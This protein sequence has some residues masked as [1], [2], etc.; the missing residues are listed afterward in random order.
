VGRLLDDVSATLRDQP[1][2][3]PAVE[4]SV[5]AAIGN[6]YRHLGA[7]EK[8]QPHLDAAL[9]LRRGVFGDHHEKVAQSLLD[10]AWT[11]HDRKDDHAAES[12]SRQALHIFQQLNLTP[13]A[14]QAS[15]C[16]QTCLKCL[17]RFE[18]A[19]QV[20][21]EALGLAE[22]AGGP[23]TVVT[24]NW[25]EATSPT[26]TGWLELARLCFDLE[27]QTLLKGDIDKV[28][29]IFI[30]AAKRGGVDDLAALQ[31]R[32]WARRG[33]AHIAARQWNT[34]IRAFSKGIEFGPHEWPLYLHRGKC[35]FQLEQFQDAVGDFTRA[36]Q[37]RP[38]DSSLWVLRGFAYV[39]LMAGGSWGF[40]YPNATFEGSL[41]FLGNSPTHPDAWS[42]Y[43]LG[44]VEPIKVEPGAT[45]AVVLPPVESEP[46]IYR[47]DVPNSGGKEYFLL[48]NRQHI[49]FDQ[50]L[51]TI[52]VPTRPGEVFS[53]G[54]GLAIWHVDD[55][56]LS[57]WCYARPNEAENWKEFRS[58]GWRKAWTG[59]SHYAISLIQADDRWDLEHFPF[60]AGDTGD[61]YPGSLGVTRFGSDTLP[62]SSSYYFWG[63]S[64]P[65]FGFSGVTVYNIAETEG[66][67]ITADL[68]YDR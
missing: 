24:A 1:N 40:W 21:R 57:T 23:N 54:H 7:P 41:M 62:N 36:V 38:Q 43:R 12:L 6:A 63:G 3:D 11:Y 25:P 50:A 20:A 32:E 18:E 22:T 29:K 39:R 58:E 4:A 28:R 16:L 37:I 9:A 5:R 47:M 60:A 53:A 56:I 45:V 66:G 46:V 31:I 35:F 15:A 68:S 42:K 27:E 34:A 49:G 67:I 51:A 14:V 44:F 17:G 33:Q 65:K 61:L 64:E 59:Q 30:E 19:E 10:L 26:S 8:A 55:T 13:H 52:T 48:E 2:Q